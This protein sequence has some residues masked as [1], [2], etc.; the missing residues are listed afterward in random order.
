MGL[1]FPI[2]PQEQPKGEE[3]SLSRKHAEIGR[4]GA[5]GQSSGNEE[6]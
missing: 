6:K 4:Y 2:Q 5:G 1:S 3:K